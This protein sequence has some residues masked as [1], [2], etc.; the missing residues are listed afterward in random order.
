M[1]QKPQII[2]NKTGSDTAVKSFIDSNVGVKIVD[3]FKQQVNELKEIQYSSNPGE[4]W[5][6][7]PWLNTLLHCVGEQALFEL[8]TN[9][10][11]LLITVDEQDKLRGAVIGVA[12][13]SVGSGIAMGAVY[14]GISDIIKI[15]DNDVLDTSNLNRLRESLLS[16]GQPKVELA[17][18][19]IYELNPFA[20]VTTF[21]Q[22]ITHD[23]IDDFFNQPKLS[24]VVD[25]IDD[26]KMKIQL[27]FKARE[28]GVPLLMFTSLGD[29]ILVDIERYDITPQSNI[30]NGLLGEV[31]DEVLASPE[32]S[33]EDIKKYSVKLVGEQYIPT[34]ALESL[35][36]LGTKLTGRPQLYST[37]A[38]DGGLAAFTIRQIILG[39]SVKSGRYFVSFSD[40]YGLEK[41]DLAD[42]SKRQTILDKLFS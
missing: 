22:G 29:N 24:A 23:N 32:I 40:F 39:A 27:R 17:A 25:E 33:T 3:L 18:R 13:M 2:S 31:P 36:L 19:K 6:Y 30:F 26:F 35:T 20:Q 1:S 16:V 4:V 34:R 12:G 28:Y 15:A 38:I 8:R 41:E 21:D 9:R 7:Y 5:V 37:I 10:N 14:S 11:K 42:T